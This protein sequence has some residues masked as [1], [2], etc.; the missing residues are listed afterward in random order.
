MLSGRTSIVIAHR[1][2]TIK[3]CDKIFFIKDKNISEIGTHKE[4]MN[5]KGDY[6]KLY[7]AQIGT[8]K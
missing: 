7:Q 5:K 3:G 8:I 2:S 1:L 6:Y 4:L